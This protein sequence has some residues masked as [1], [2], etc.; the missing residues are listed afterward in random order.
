M[1]ELISIDTK[2]KEIVEKRKL[3]DIKI[4]YTNIEDINDLIN[5]LNLL[6]DPIIDS[7]KNDLIEIYK[8]E[9]KMNINYIINLSYSYFMDNIDSEN[10]YSSVLKNIQNSSFYSNYK[11]NLK[12]QKMEFYYL[13]EELEKTKDYA[14]ILIKIIEFS[15]NVFDLELKDEVEELIKEVEIKKINHEKNELKKLLH[16]QEFGKAKI[17]YENLL[18][19]Y[20]KDYINKNLRLEYNCLL[21][22][23]KDYQIE[24]N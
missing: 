24:L 8:K 19:Q 17:K 3:K 9:K 13:I 4:C 6:N 16:L 22:Q 21:K 1:E 5:K 20:K 11:S 10:D 12:I 7:K 15:K 23:I 18:K 2:Y 14:N